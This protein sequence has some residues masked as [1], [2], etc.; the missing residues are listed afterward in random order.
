MHH[1]TQPT[2]EQVRAYMSARER[3]RHPPPPPDEIRRQL[4]WR[5]GRA[6]REPLLVLVLVW[7]AVFGQ[8]AALIA[9][10]WMC[11]PARWRDDP[12]AHA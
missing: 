8:L 4:G 6:E 3:A 11:A 5:L 12:A 7:P 1:V 9:L 10:D 2:K